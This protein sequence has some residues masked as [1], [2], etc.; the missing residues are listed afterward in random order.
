[1]PQEEGREFERRLGEIVRKEIEQ[2]PSLLQ[3]DR[4][5]VASLV[6]GAVDRTRIYTET[7]SVVQERQISS[8]ATQAAISQLLRQVRDNMQK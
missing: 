7:K 4:G 6:G 8:E 2:D 3:R 5:K 1:M